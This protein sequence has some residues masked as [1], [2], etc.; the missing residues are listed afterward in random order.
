MRG[1]QEHPTPTV[2]S[3]TVQSSGSGGGFVLSSIIGQSDS[4]KSS[5]GDIIINS[6]LWHALGTV[7]PPPPG[8]ELYLPLVIR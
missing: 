7:I 8:T 5:G 3:V 6:G 1:P 2:E 4:G